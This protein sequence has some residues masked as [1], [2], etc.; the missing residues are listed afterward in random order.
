M[1]KIKQLKEYIKESHRIVFFGGAG[2]STESG[3]PDFEVKMDYMR[4]ICL[5][6]DNMNQNII[7][8]IPVSAMIPR[9]FIDFIETFWIPELMNQMLPIKYWQN[10]RNRENFLVI[11]QNIDGLHQKAGSQKVYEI[12][13]SATRC[14]CMKCGKEY[15]N[16]RILDS[17]EKIPD[18]PA[19]DPSAQ[20]SFYMKN[21]CRKKQ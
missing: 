18:V 4:K 8:L 19:V 12:H 3:I 6:M 17:D 21:N 13:G 16:D 15:T 7:F 2:V 20:T 11:T 1:D 5:S 14:Y 10:G 9:P